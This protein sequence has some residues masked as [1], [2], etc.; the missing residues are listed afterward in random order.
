MS[1]A[2]HRGFFLAL[3]VLL[4]A[5]SIYSVVAVVL[6]LADRRYIHY[7]AVAVVIAT[8][9]VLALAVLAA[10][11]ARRSWRRAKSN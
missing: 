1:K 8:I 6:G 2:L 3:A 5:F 7:R 10:F 9:L 11:L 4:G